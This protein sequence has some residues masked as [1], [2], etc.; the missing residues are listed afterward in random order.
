MIADL[1]ARILTLLKSSGVSFDHLEHEHV[2]TSQEAALARGT[3]IEDAAKALVFETES[4]R[5]AECVVSGHRRVD[6]KKLKII[7]GEKNVALASPK[8]VFEATGCTVG[9]VPPFGNLFSPPLPVYVDQEVL[10]R[11]R[12][13]FSAG[14]HY[15]SIRMRPDDWLSLV[16]PVIADLRKD[17][18]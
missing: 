7:L 8:R 6:L 12:I 1:H 3:R 17:A 2:H 15:H 16:K 9:C 10:T 14:S 13:V 4:G 18:D 11:E 5:L